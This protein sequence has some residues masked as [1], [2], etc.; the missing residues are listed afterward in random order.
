MD[1]KLKPW[2]GIPREKISWHPTVDETLCIGCG[3]C[4]TGCGRLV[5]RYD[6]QDKKAVVKDPDS[7]AVGCVTC[8]NICPAHAVSFPPVSHIHRLIKEHEL[9]KKAR[10][11][12][13]TNH[14]KYAV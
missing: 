3:L 5:F 10:E 7:C 2:H 12:L 11:E 1:A 9:I 4:V 8:A 6:Y 14:E 13:K